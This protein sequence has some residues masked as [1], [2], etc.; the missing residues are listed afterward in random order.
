MHRKTKHKVFEFV[1][2]I[3]LTA[4]FCACLDRDPSQ[5][6]VITYEIETY[7]EK[8][9]CSY[10]GLD[11]LIVI[12]NS[13]SMAAIQSLLS[14]SIYTLIDSLTNPTPDGLFPLENIRVAVVTSDMGLQYGEKDSNEH[15]P[16]GDNARFQTAMPESVTLPD[17]TI[18]KCPALDSSYSYAKTYVWDPPNVNLATQAACLTVQDT[19]GHEIQQPL[20]AALRAL[21]DSEQPVFIEDSHLLGILVVSDSE[22]CSIA[23]KDLFSTDAFTEGPVSDG[24]A[25]SGCN[26]P[27]SNHLFDTSRYWSKLAEVKGNYLP[28]FFSAIVGVPP[29]EKCEGRGNELGECLDDPAMEYKIQTVGDDEDQYVHVSP[30]CKLLDGDTEIISA[31]PARRMVSVAQDFDHNGSVH[32]ICN[33]DWSG[34]IDHLARDIRNNTYRPCWDEKLDWEMLTH[35]EQLEEDCPG[36]GKSSCVMIVEAIRYGSRIDEG[37][38]FDTGDARVIADITRNEQGEILS[39][40]LLCPMPKL[41]TPLDCSEA[42]ALIPHHT[43]EEIGWYYCETND[44]E[45]FEDACGDRQDNDGDGATDCNDLECQNCTVC[46]GS[47]VGCRRDCLYEINL[48]HAAQIVTSGSLVSIQCMKHAP[49]DDTNCQEKKYGDAI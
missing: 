10:G 25:V 18:A 31:H 37:C 24:L 13:E 45:N 46:G 43:S 2:I 33:E 29:G 36:C 38:P 3:V 4:T 27:D 26:M 41:P 30:A 7:G 47:G 8:V 48:T 32:S 49:H 28:V 44:R 34:A 39:K 1:S 17:G 35:S 20:E 14:T 42:R 23:S 21:T 22:D 5:S 12:D 11:L 19:D 15:G 16:I 9:G 6:C 40:S